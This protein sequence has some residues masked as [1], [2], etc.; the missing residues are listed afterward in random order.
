[1]AEPFAFNI[2]E[3]VLETLTAL[4]VQEISLAC[5]VQSDFRKLREMLATVKPWIL[6]AEE[7]QARNNQLQDWVQKLKDA[8]YDAEDVLDEFEVESLRGQV[9]EQ[10]C[11]GNKVCNFFSSSNPLVFRLKMAHKIKKITE[12]FSEIADLRDRFHLVE[13]H[14]DT[15][16]VVLSDRETHSFVQASDVIGR[17]IDKKKIVESLLQAPTGGE[18]ENISVLTIVGIG[19][20]GKTAL[21]KLVFNDVNVAE[22]FQLKMWV[23]V[24]NETDLKRL[25]EKVI[26]VANGG[27]RDYGNMSLEKLQKGLRGCL[28]GKT[29][30]LILDDV[31]WV[32]D[33]PW[34]KLKPL[35]MGGA[36]GS[37]IL[38]TARSNL[39]ASNMGTIHNL[40]ALPEEESFSL[41][42]K[43]AFRKGGKE[44]HPHLVQI[45]RE[46]VKKCGGNPLAV[47]TLASLL[48]STTS[49]HEWEKVRDNE[50]W[51][52]MQDKNDLL[53]VLKLSYD[54]LPH[55]LKPC[56]VYCSVYPKDYR[57]ASFELVQFWMAHG[58]LKTSNPDEDPE[59]TGRRY[60]NEL[61]SR[62]FFQD[63]ETLGFIQHFKMH[64]LLHD[65]ALLIAKNE[66]SVVKSQ[67]QDVGEGVRHLYFLD[68]DIPAESFSRYLDN[69]CH[70]RTFRFLYIKEGSRND[71][72]IQTFLSRFQRLRVLDL[73]ESTFE[74]L[75]RGIGNL[76]HLRFL[77][78]RGN[79]N[80]KKLPNSICKLQ[81]LQTLILASCNG[82]EEFP[83]DMSQLIMLRAL[84][85]T[86]NLTVLPENVVNRLKSLRHLAIGHCENLE[87]LPEGVRNLTQ[88][89]TLVIGMCKN[90]ISLPHGL[91]CLT[92]LENLAILHCERLELEGKEDNSQ[93]QH[94]AQG[95]RLRRLLL[96]GLP[97]LKTLPK[98][99][100]IQ[101]SGSHT[102]S[103]E[104]LEIFG[105]L[106]LASLPEVMQ[107]LTAL[108]E[109]KI[110]YCPLL[111]ERCRRK[112]GE[113][114]P[115]IAH[116][117]YIYLDGNEIGSNRYHKT[118][119]DHRGNQ[120]RSSTTT[121]ISTNISLENDWKKEE[122]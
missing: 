83:K 41:F 6:D 104:M 20:L 91:N 2:A 72:F 107:C 10:K 9:L 57:F 18:E 38:V 98:W 55:Y 35:L 86:T 71:F 76:K 7:K 64:D 22:F 95:L 63:F 79:R 14:D 94:I 32:D 13:K 40:K 99:L 5:G 53:P 101:G 113:D 102:L 48:Y 27:D 92:N 11:I 90:L 44:Q 96:G 59:E 70:V 93:E 68:L 116:V 60:L 58:L 108:V 80:I 56:F 49:K 69:C 66:C 114:W 67:G 43:V 39:V 23:C 62:Y 31:C 121:V 8:C 54:Q 84:S 25:L 117:P 118:E 111:S 16:H 52:L 37:K 42:L 122:R 46:I 21:A 17:D 45:G 33:K 109:L 26:K 77:D 29:Y 97:K 74:V 112:T 15:M 100:L 61:S 115:K 30:L 85:I 81:N 110:E 65:L 36:K 89:R 105:C 51:K 1:M 3:N 24:S 119:G 19:G 87:H 28:N 73:S 120:S 88:L 106:E 103:L 4:V 75:P 78:L 47:K 50:M 82:I 12:R 34:S